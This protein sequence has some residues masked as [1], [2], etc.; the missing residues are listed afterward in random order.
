MNIRIWV[1]TKPRVK[2]I[3]LWWRMTLDMGR[4]LGKLYK[5]NKASDML[6]MLDQIRETLDGFNY[7]ETDEEGGI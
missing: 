7:A 6:N 4:A 2:L 3:R 1:G 5:H